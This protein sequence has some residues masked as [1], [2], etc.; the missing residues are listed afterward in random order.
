MRSPFGPGIHR[1]PRFTP[2]IRLRRQILGPGC[3]L[4]GLALS[5][6]APD[7]VPLTPQV[8][9]G[10]WTGSFSILG[11]TVPLTIEVRSPAADGM[12][13]AVSMVERGV[14][15]MPA[16]SVEIDGEE[17]R[18]DFQ[19]LGGAYEGSLTT[20]GQLEGDW[21]QAGGRFRLSLTATDDPPSAK[22]PQLPRPPFPYG[23]EEVQFE[24][25]APGVVLAG[26]LTLPPASGPVPGVVLVS[27]SGPQ[28]RDEQVFGHR[29]FMVIADHLTQ[30]GIAVLRYDD[31]GVGESTGDFSMAAIPDFAT[32]AQAAVRFLRSHPE[33]DRDRIGIVGHS[34][35]GWAGP[36]AATRI[37]GEVA[38]LVL[39]A[40]VGMDGRGLLALQTEKILEASGVPPP[41]LAFNKRIQD[42]ILDAV[43]AAEEGG[44]LTADLQ[45]EF[46]EA[47]GGLPLRAAEALGIAGRINR[48]I[49]EQ[50]SLVA[51]P[52]LRSFLTF[53]PVSTLAGITVPVLALNGST[54]LQVPPD[55]NLRLI[56]EALEQAGNDDVT[57]VE[58]DG[59][60][61]MFQPSETGLPSDYGVI[62]TTIDPAVL[63]LMTE[64]IV[65][66]VGSGDRE[67]RP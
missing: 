52:W 9:E 48:A 26:T 11:Q 55:P 10:Y 42:E 2:R 5:S 58:L 15:D 46:R 27:G 45:K 37:P 8:L 7:T 41:L 56:A 1:P 29:P 43:L 3:I 54:D 34:E 51:S 30:A 28:D 40:A 63:H 18:I 23:V 13:A 24:S 38:F 66:R 60:N 33:L 47:L 17:L 44:D 31:R 20:G 49:E 39:M 22:R 36:L 25:D 62:E 67:Q 14:F 16:S 35:G 65:E 61:H 6:C 50:A 64:W 57:T 21:L 59:L 4:L 53:D 12:E 19:Q 32:D